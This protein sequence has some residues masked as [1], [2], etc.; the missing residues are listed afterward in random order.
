MTKSDLLNLWSQWNR[1]KVSPPYP[2]VLA[3]TIDQPKTNPTLKSWVH[4][5][6]GCMCLERPICASQN[7]SKTTVSH[8]GMLHNCIVLLQNSSQFQFLSVMT[9]FLQ[10]E[11][12]LLYIGRKE[13]ISQKC[14]DKTMAYHCRDAMATYNHTQ[15]TD[16]KTLLYLVTVVK[17]PPPPP[18]NVCVWEVICCDGCLQTLHKL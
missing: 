4:F 14:V 6:A 11:I 7:S 10:I 15:Y 2:A 3:E 18:N 12:S 17:L 1:V 5:K 8:D 13:I 9:I 16:D